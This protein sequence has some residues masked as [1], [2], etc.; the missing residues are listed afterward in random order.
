[1]LKKFIQISLTIFILS[2]PL[3]SSAELFM[4]PNTYKYIETGDSI[5]KVQQQCGAPTSKVTRDQ[6][7]KKKV[8]VEHLFYHTGN[9]YRNLSVTATV[10]VKDGKV[11]SI[12]LGSANTQGSD[13]CEGGPIA[14]GD[15][16]IA[17]QNNCGTPAFTNRSTSMESRGY[18][19]VTQWLYDFGN[20]QPNLTLQ[21][22]NGQL[23]TIKQQ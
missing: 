10:T 11:T 5:A 17:V 23:E 7:V 22:V 3:Q 12:N 19:K 9:G 1:M 14:V 21:F 6:Q 2:A 15:S 8:N 18:K 16:A 20:N 13:F 4:C